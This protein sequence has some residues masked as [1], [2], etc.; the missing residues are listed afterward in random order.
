MQI[1]SSYRKCQ[2]LA[3]QGRKTYKHTKLSK[4]LRGF[5]YR[6]SMRIRA[7]LIKS[8]ARVFLKPFSI[9]ILASKTSKPFCLKGSKTFSAHVENTD[10]NCHKADAT[11]QEQ[12]HTCYLTESNGTSMCP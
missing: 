6:T 8:K 10:P 12:S 4:S 1:P 9:L 7:Q 3:T 2:I 5:P 11:V